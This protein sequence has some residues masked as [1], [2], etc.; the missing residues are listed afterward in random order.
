MVTDVTFAAAAFT[1]A[2][3]PAAFPIVL[4]ESEKRHEQCKTCH[5]V[6]KGKIRSYLAETHGGN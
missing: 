5:S 2:V 6:I 4:L 1:V 3:Y